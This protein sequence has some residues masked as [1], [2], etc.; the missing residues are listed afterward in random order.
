MRKTL[1]LVFVLF[2][3]AMCIKTNVQDY[4]G[5]IGVVAGYYDGKDYSA[6]ISL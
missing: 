3:M 5:S 2:I 6:K 4:K 1:I